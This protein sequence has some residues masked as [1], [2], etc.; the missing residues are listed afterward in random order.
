MLPVSR[1]WSLC[2]EVKM[3]ISKSSPSLP[4]GSFVPIGE[5]VVVITESVGSSS[6]EI[7]CMDPESTINSPKPL[8]T[9]AFFKI[10]TTLGIS[11]F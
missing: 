9:A 10:D 3:D 8:P 5:L 11:T 1:Q 7:A 6:A 2:A 4:V